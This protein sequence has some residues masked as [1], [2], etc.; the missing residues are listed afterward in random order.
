[1]SQSNNHLHK[2]FKSSLAHNSSKDK[3]SL[4]INDLK[5]KLT[6]E[7]Q[8]VS[9]HGVKQGSNLVVRKAESLSGLG[10]TFNSAKSMRPASESLTSKNLYLAQ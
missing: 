7:N 8:Q 6:Y 10:T 4:L 2:G 5:K 1:M 9:G 3:S